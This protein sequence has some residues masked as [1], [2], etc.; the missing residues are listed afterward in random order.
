M[1][2]PPHYASSDLMFDR[3]EILQNIK[4]PF[5]PHSQ[6]KVSQF[7]TNKLKNERSVVDITQSLQDIQLMMELQDK[8][9]SHGDQILLE[10]SKGYAQGFQEATL[11]E[12]LKRRQIAKV[13]TAERKQRLRAMIDQ[14]SQYYMNV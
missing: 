7:Q 13:L 6:E 3:P 11:A 9:K 2:H 5:F 1:S 4:Q 8:T 14:P 10:L 12:S